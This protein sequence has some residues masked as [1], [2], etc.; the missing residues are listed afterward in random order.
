MT[1]QRYGD[2][3]AFRSS[4]E[5]RI[6]TVARESGMPH[7][8]LR[9]E[10]AFQRLIARFIA[11]GDDRWAIKGGVALLWRIGKEA[12]TTRDVD[13]NWSGS[14]NDL[15]EFLDASIEQDLSDWFAFEMGEPR[16]LQ[17]EA[18]GALR[19]GVTTR[20]AGREFTAF[21]LDVNFAADQPF[22]ETVAT[23]LP[24]LEFVGLADLAVPMISIAQQLAEKLHAVMRTYSSGDSSRAKDA[25]DTML[26]AQIVG[27][28]E[29]D[30]L[31]EAVERTFAIRDTPLPV[32][33]ADLPEEWAEPLGA[34][35]SGFA[36]PGIEGLDELETSWSHLWQP[37]LDGRCSG[38]AAWDPAAL[39]WV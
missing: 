34:L 29:A 20:L 7:D 38:S 37:I 27:L 18:E 13:T 36:L 11:A 22:T 39:L 19:F 8:R 4:L 10:I 12:R 17:G 35:L 9:K 26:L 31:R 6:G 1:V 24:L 28:P 33:P 2:A 14:E 15:E 25:Y 21:R 5:Q 16:P 32:A 23:H 3:E 30:V